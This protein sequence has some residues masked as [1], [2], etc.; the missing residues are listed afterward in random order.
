LT[1]KYFEYYNIDEIEI[2]KL[3]TARQAYKEV[4]INKKSDADADIKE[5]ILKNIHGENW[6][7][8]FTP[9]RNKV[10]LASI[11]LDWKENK[12][13]ENTGTLKAEDKEKVKKW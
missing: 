1:R 11:L 7:Q 9:K 5:A 3:K 6:Q 13:F 10:K 12:H 8:K 4:K 2:N